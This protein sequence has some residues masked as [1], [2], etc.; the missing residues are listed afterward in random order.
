MK[1]RELS[2]G[3]I[4][5]GRSR[6]YTFTL[7]NS[8]SFF[9]LGGNV[10]T[11]FALKL[12]AGNFLVGLLAASVYLGYLGML[13]GLPL[14][15]RLGTVRT[16]GRFWLLRYLL[17]VP[18]LAT[19]LLAR[20]GSSRTALAL[21]TG[22]VLGFNIARGV[23]IT[24]Y[25]PIMGQLAA[26]RGRGAFLA[27]LQALSHLASLAAGAAV[28]FFLGREASL[29]RY[30]LFIGFGTGIGFLAAFTIFRLPEPAESAGS[31]LRELLPGFRRAMRRTPF[32]KFM[33]VHLVISLAALMVT[34]FLIVYV[35]RVYHQP[36]NYVVFYTL[37]GSLGALLM[38]LISG[39]MID[40]LGAKPLFFI[41]TAV[42]LLTLVPLG[43]S[44]PLGG[45]TG[46]WIF[47][48]L[49]FF[50]HSMGTFGIT[51]SGQTYFLAAIQPEERLNLGVA[52]YL[53]QG[54]ASGIGSLAGGALLEGLQGVLALPDTKTYQLYFTFLIVLFAAGL[55]LVRNLENLG[56]YPIRDAL[57][58]IFSPRDLRAIGLLHR[59][60]RSRTATEEH[61]ALQALAE[62]PSE[63]T[64]RDLLQKLK[65]PRFTIRAQALTA[66]GRLP[67][68]GPVA[69]ALVS[70]VKNHPFTTAYM[71]AEILGDRRIAAAVPV[72]RRQLAS[73]D[74]FLSGK[75]MVALARLDDRPSIPAI[76]SVLRWTRNPRLVIHAA[77]ALE[78]FRNT[79]SIPLLLSRLEQRAH[80]FLR[81]EII[82]AIAG[83]LGLEEWF[84]P[85]YASFLEKSTEAVLRLRDEME[86]YGPPSLSADR[87]ATLLELLL[88]PDRRGFARLA[89]RLL[90]ELEPVTV[91]APLS[92]ALKNPRYQRLD[93]FCFLV[94]AVL[95]RFSL[96]PPP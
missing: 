30:T 24:G 71:A 92:R 29:A 12:G 83:I 86:R 72:L 87:L 50:F 85:L 49:I 5:R 18:V 84:Y 96:H 35:K 46:V 88:R 7:L 63:L 57:G 75:C 55:L 53:A 58:A 25:N 43:L 61:T 21:V 6:F 39:F 44:P 91:T 32:R 34:P 95:V 19:P 31:L 93:R 45:G 56:A 27:R 74:Y 13:A 22:G 9:L 77:T 4:L 59:L 64:I 38:A 14:I 73:R 37:S 2:P 28:A 16:M 79:L 36:D 1:A 33:I 80:P 62:F 47:C 20:M 69:R 67:A 42:L 23:A 94:T 90:G 78:I 15:P 41:F 66:L 60:F 17:L 76:E 70:E 65:S 54:L 89:R 68:T 11:L 48:S 52:Y 10:I 82:L 3:E 81:D 40:K 26:E 8:F 51:S